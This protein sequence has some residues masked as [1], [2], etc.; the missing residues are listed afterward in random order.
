MI[1]WAPLRLALTSILTT[2]L[3]LTRHSD[4]TKLMTPDVDNYIR[5]VI[6]EWDLPGLSVGLVRQDPTSPTG[7]YQEFA[8]YGVAKAD[9]TPVT[10]DTVF[11]IA[12]NSK[13]FTA[14]GTGLLIS[15]E[16]LKEERGAELTWS[17][18]A[19]DI[20][21]GLWELWD[22]EASR[23]TSIQDMLSHRTGLPGHDIGNVKRNQSLVDKIR[24]LRYLR[25]SAEFRELWQYNNLMYDSLAYLPQ[26]LVNQSFASYMEQHIFHP[27]C[28]SSTTYSIAQ[29]EKGLLANGFV[30]SGQDQKLG[31]DGVQKPIVPFFV[32]PGDEYDLAGCGGVLSSARDLTVWLAM[33]LANGKHPFENRTVIPPGVIEYTATGTS[34]FGKLAKFPEL[35]VAVYG[36]GQIRYSYRGHEIVEHNGGVPGFDSWVSRMPNDNLGIVLLCND[37]R[38]MNALS[39]IKWRIIDEIIVRDVFPNAPLIDWIPRYKAIEDAAKQRR[40]TFTPRPKHPLPPNLPLSELQGRVYSHGAYG[41]LTPCLV[42]GP[43]SLLPNDNIPRSKAEATCQVILESLPVQRI[44]NITDLSVPTFIIPLNGVW[45]THL[46]LSHFSGNLFNTSVLWTNAQA[47]LKESL[48]STSDGTWTG[49]G[50]VVA[51]FTFQDILVEWV[52]EGEEGLAFRGNVWN[53]GPGASEPAGNGK[54]GAEVWFSRVA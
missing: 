17:T 21:G 34:T 3:P 50:D 23:G 49:D 18:K 24:T 30:H 1:S 22:E 52:T 51:P 13:L 4:Q 40:T 26:T 14:I 12:S 38:S 20:F 11:A 33:L 46:R 16:S 45:T 10:P 54:D 42:P 47:R 5:S 7:W 6:E 41:T 29:A 32:R 28:M 25:P 15:N 39:A 27:L 44:L 35:S 48:G 2:Q 19:K 53:M 36:A 9:G 8:S 31:L 43:Q 37:E